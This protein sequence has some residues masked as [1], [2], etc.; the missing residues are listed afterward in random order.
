MSRSLCS[1]AARGL[2]SPTHPSRGPYKARQASPTP[3]LKSMHFCGATRLAW[4]QDKAPPG[5]H[6]AC[7]SVLH[8]WPHLPAECLRP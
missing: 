5:A 2:F 6:G 3:A 8:H 7:W 1:R 4:S